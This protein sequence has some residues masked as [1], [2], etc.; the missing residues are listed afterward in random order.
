[1]QPLTIADNSAKTEQITSLYLQDEYKPV[2]SLTLNYGLRYD[3]YSAYTNGHQFSPR[4]NIVW[5]A[6]PAL[7]LHGGY[8][9]YLS[10]PPFELVGSETVSKFVG[11]TAAPPV[12][13]ADTPQAERA[14]YLDLGAQLRLSSAIGIGID[15]YYKQSRH[16][17][18]E[19]QFGA[20]II[21]T[22]F[23]FRDGRQAGVELSLD[24][25]GKALAGYA[26]LA[27]QSARGRGIESAQF[28]FP[29]AELDYI[30]THYIDLDHEQKITGAAGLSYRRGGTRV[31]G[32]LTFGS[33]LRASLTLPDGS[34]I[35]NGAHLPFHAQ[36]NLGLS[37]EFKTGIDRSVTLRLDLINALDRVYE[38]RDGTGVG[39]GAPQYGPRRGV[40]AGITFG[41]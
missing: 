37:H 30:A 15:T 40:F 38:I 14:H 16:L 25:A 33:G 28:N 23:N 22:P 13:R 6:S 29:Q 8:S 32:D 35:P 9:R 31:S 7:T 21:L 10:P 18:D 5:Q 17:I 19:G 39:V 41:F 34:T 24:Y 2:P 4:L 12:G 20:P 36:L 26:N 11:T 27:F 1:E 3:G